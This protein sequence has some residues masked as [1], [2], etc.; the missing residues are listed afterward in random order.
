[1]F[2]IQVSPTTD[3]GRVEK[4]QLLR[5]GKDDKVDDHDEKDD[6]DIPT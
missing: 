1:M 3:F 4:H 2:F 5:K 6:N